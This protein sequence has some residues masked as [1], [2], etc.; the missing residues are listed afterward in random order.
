MRRRAWIKRWAWRF[1]PFVVLTT[2][3]LVFMMLVSTKPEL[4]QRDVAEKVW[5]VRAISGS[6]GSVQPELRLFGEVVA[7]REVELRPLVGGR[8]V[9][10]GENFQDG[11][12]VAAGALLIAIDPFDYEATVAEAQAD[13]AEASARLRELGAESEAAK[14]MLEQDKAVEELRQRDLNRFASLS[15]RGAA[16]TKSYDDARMALLSA[17]ERVIDRRFAIERLDAN[18]ARQ[19]AVIAKLEVKAE[20]AARDL[21]QT[22]LTAP[23]AG[24]L[25]D[26]ATQVGKRVS[27]SD[28]VAR[29]I[30]SSRL[31]VRFNVGMQQFGELLA[32]DELV[33]RTV[34]VIWRLRNQPRRFQAVIDRTGSEID[35]ASG[36]IAVFA[37][38][39]AGDGIELLRPGAFVEV[40][41]PGPRYDGVLRLPET[42]WHEDKVLIVDEGRLA[43]R[44]AT[45]VRRVGSEILVRASIQ[46]DEP[47]LVTPIPGAEAGMRVTLVPDGS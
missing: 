22:E 21:N 15:Q 13:L 4:A 33:G 32:E 41:I 26:I 8:V 27:Q 11:G 47:V 17:T 39:D 3:A 2:G 20:R 46:A 36:G 37:R 42:A 38:I 43:A 25:T 23:F 31:E 6:P 40:L 16:S 34:E 44:P 29:L 28:R 5:P 45:L 18:L 14:A 24:Y 35:T 19:E 30:D 12:K 1:L 9:R 7:G 10:V